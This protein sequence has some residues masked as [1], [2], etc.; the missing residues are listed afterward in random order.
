MIFSNFSM[1]Q[2]NVEVAFK[3]VPT[4]DIFMKAL[5]LVYGN[6]HG[7]GLRGFT[8]RLARELGVK[9]LVRNLADGS[10]QLFLDGPS[11]A[12]EQLVKTLEQKKSSSF[13]G[14][15]VEKI[16]IFYEGETGFRQ[17]WRNYEGF[18]VDY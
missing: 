1:K 11:Y 3:F 15:H 17:A 12:I 5:V 6:V 8:A 9:G 18:E 2:H 16:E 14:P 13:F 7:V 4:L 10:V